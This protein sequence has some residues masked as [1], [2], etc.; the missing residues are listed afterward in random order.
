MGTK[1]DI[2][3]APTLTELQAMVGLLSQRMGY[4]KASP[5]TLALGICEE[6][7]EIASDVL[8]YYTSDYTRNK[9]K[10][11]EVRSA[12][13]TA[14]EMGDIIT[15]VLQLCNKLGITPAFKWADKGE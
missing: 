3:K 4:D 2:D 10:T 15:Y 1:V 8:R 9:S 5:T 13:D 11:T 6:A 7:G 12:K 14:Y